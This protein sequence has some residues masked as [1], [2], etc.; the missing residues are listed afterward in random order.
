MMNV[1]QLVELELSGKTEVL[2]ENLPQCH[3]FNH[4]P[5]ITLSGIETGP[6]Q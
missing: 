3:F 2:R 4:K 5:H 1:E 6:L